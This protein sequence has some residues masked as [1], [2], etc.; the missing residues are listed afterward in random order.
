MKVAACDCTTADYVAWYK[1][2]VSFE[3]KAVRLLVFAILVAAFVSLYGSMSNDFVILGASVAMVAC[4]AGAWCLY[5][6]VR[7]DRELVRYRQ[8]REGDKVVVRFSKHGVEVE[9]DGKRASYSFKKIRKA[10][11]VPWHLFLFLEGEDEPLIIDKKKIQTV[12]DD[13]EPYYIAKK[14]R[15]QSPD[16]KYVRGNDL[17]YTGKYARLLRN[18]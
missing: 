17:T 15:E 9:K 18:G 4:A 1:Y 14:L 2:R 7:L 10:R 8:E 13:L 6:K 5:S 11:E 16:Y 3:E 12:A